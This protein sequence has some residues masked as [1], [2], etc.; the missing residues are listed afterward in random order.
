[1]T[2]F[3]LS[4]LMTLIENIS[5]CTDYRMLKTCSSYHPNHNEKSATGVT[6]A[7]R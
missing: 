1:M 7:P 3:A 5:Y 6:F 4:G 2:T